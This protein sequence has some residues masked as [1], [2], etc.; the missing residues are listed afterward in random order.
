MEPQHDY[1]ESPYHWYSISR[2]ADEKGKG[3]EWMNL[4]LLKKILVLE[5]FNTYLKLNLIKYKRIELFKRKISFYI[6]YFI[7]IIVE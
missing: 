6:K 1:Y 2:W 3:N 5:Y 7:T 4:P